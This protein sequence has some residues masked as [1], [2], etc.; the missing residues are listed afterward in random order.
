MNNE[1]RGSILV[2][3]DD[4]GFRSL[5]VNLLRPQGFKVVEASSPDEA[6]SLF[7]KKDTV[8][9]IV[10]YRLPQMDGMSWIT[11]LREAGANVPVVFCSAIPCDAKTFSWL[12]NILQVAMIVQ[13]PIVPSA[14]LQQIESLLP[15][16][17]KDYSSEGI[18][19]V[20]E[21]DTAGDDDLQADI[22]MR[23]QISQLDKKVKVAQALQNA[24]QEYFIQLDNDWKVLIAKIEQR[25]H[26]AGDEAALAEAIRI[27]HSIRGTAGSLGL[28]DIGKLAGQ[29]EDFLLSL[30]P[31]DSTD[32]EIYW[33]EIIR[34]AARGTELIK[35]AIKEAK[36][37]KPST[38]RNRV[39][40][41]SSN[42]NIIEAAQED[43]TREFAHVQGTDNAT[44]FMRYAAENRLDAVILDTA[45]DTASAFHNAEKVRSIQ[46][47][48]S[49]PIGCICLSEHALSDSD[50][51]YLGASEKIVQP[52]NGENL[53][54][55]IKRLLE[56]RIPGQ[57][58]IL[59]VDDDEV[60]CKFVC[61]VLNDQRM[62]ASY[63]TNPTLVMETMETIQPDLV[64]LDLMMPVV[65][66]YEVCR[67]IRSEE[68]W[69]D[70]PVLFLTSKTDQAARSAAFAVGA[71]D[72][73]TKPVLAEELLARV[74]AQLAMASRKRKDRARDPESGMLRGEAYMAEAADLLLSH[75]KEGRPLAIALIEIDDFD[76]LTI[77]QGHHGAQAVAQA[78]SSMIHARFTAETLRC[79]WS[80]SG[81][82]LAVPGT[83]TAILAGA[84]SRLLS[85]FTRVKFAGSTHKFAA[86]FSAGIADSFQDGV[87]LEEIIKGAHH[88]LRTGRREKVGVISS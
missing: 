44:T 22:S 45:P 79:R 4:A 15:S 21:S 72:F 85:D 46:G 58:R 41:L 77:V 82:A 76:E 24:R 74:A 33:S 28:E 3:D 75:Q 12:R 34:A 43:E 32:Q 59:V 18:A 19:G 86:T 38:V 47:N 61:G 30:D 87:E 39:L 25:N 80:S 27:T 81:F 66:G 54:D 62:D 57:P 48:E 67:H 16:Y 9:A 29:M 42:D 68:K 52:I 50:V 2:L 84:V 71:N 13:K 40:I 55:A 17:V 36:L 63:E 1:S 64:L 31:W 26:N 69:S 78:L 11:K 6:F 7:S 23:E 70:V 73:L 5:I 10:D 83:D 20:D 56:V 35:D 37:V 8:L 49:I 60:L 14:F 53:R 88:R 51:L 65:T